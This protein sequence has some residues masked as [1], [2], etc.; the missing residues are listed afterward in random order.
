QYGE[1]ADITTCSIGRD[2]IPCIQPA[3]FATPESS[4]NAVSY[5]VSRIYINS[6]AADVGNFHIRNMTCTLVISWTTMPTAHTDYLG[7]EKIA[8]GEP[9]DGICHEQSSN[10]VFVPVIIVC[11]NQD[12]LPKYSAKRNV[13][14]SR[15]SLSPYVGVYGLYELVINL[16]SSFASGWV[17]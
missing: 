4:G 15:R 9:L 17:S 5:Q 1:L 16:I 2:H 14:F 13:G 11:R 3:G 6:K 10:P 8:N 12:V 7:V